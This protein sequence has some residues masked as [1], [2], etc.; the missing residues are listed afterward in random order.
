MIIIN[1]LLGSYGVGI[2]VRFQP[3]ATKQAMEGTRLLSITKAA[4]AA[5]AADTRN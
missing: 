2:V 3:E 4:A 1:T 5:A